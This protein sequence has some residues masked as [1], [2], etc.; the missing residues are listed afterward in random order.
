M[1]SRMPTDDGPHLPAGGGHG[2]PV[3][4]ARLTPHRSLGQRGF[5]LLMAFTAVTFFIS[6]MLFLAI[7]AWPVVFFLG[8]DALILWLAFH[9]SYR[10]GRIAEE[11]SVRRDEITI[12]RIDA[13]GRMEAHHFN[14]FWTR[15]TVDRHEEFGITRMVLASR[16]RELPIGAFLNPLDRESF[17]R[18]FSKALASSRN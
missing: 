15:F 14:P 8:L 17:A 3:F 18:A 4:A 1:Q 12:R 6:G 7:G 10:N 5:F 2:E 13:A 16:G 9:L 11:V